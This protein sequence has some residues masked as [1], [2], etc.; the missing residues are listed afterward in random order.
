MTEMN[1]PDKFDDDVGEITVVMKPCV[2]EI[3]R[4][5]IPSMGQIKVGTKM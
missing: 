4:F 2:R 3:L 1:K 5:K